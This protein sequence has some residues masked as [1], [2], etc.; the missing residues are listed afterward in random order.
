MVSPYVCIA[1]RST[2]RAMLA[3]NKA[4]LMSRL[5]RAAFGAPPRTNEGEASDEPVA[6]WIAVLNQG[7]RIAAQTLEC[8]GDYRSAAACAVVFADAL[9]A[10]GDRLVPGV[11]DPEDLLSLDNLA[12]ALS[13]RG[14][15]AVNRPVRESGAGSPPTSAEP[16]SLT[17]SNPTKPA[18]EWRSTRLQGVLP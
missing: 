10:D 1:E 18:N 8:R 11:F 7:K 4:A 6:H 13:Q 3:L 15:V 2:H 16:R 12:A 5:Q 14:I 17:A 9:T